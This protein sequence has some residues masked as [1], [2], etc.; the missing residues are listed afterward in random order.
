MK[1]RGHRIRLVVISCI[2]CSAIVLLVRWYDK[3]KAD[4][5]LQA[6]RE[7]WRKAR[8]DLSLLHS[9]DLIFRHGRGIVSSTLWSLSQTDKRYSHA[10][11]LSI[12]EG[13][14]Y[15]YHCIGGEDNPNERM[16]RDR[17][18][19]FCDPEV[20]HSFGIYRLPMSDSCHALFMRKVREG[21]DTGV[22]FDTNFDLDTDEKQYCTEFIYRSLKSLEG[23][24]IQLSSS[25]Y[26]GREYIACDNL[27]LVPNTL[28]IHH[29]NY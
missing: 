17:L 18:S 11:V 3:G 23:S 20:A 14:A 25:W 22:L 9:G 24:D 5:S 16:S 4:L 26:A 19:R 8:P 13:E 21:F 1:F 6:R 27:Y 28:F 7:L 29:F 10:G 2:A 12:E 15:V